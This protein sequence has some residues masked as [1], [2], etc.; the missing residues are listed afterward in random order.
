MLGI[1]LFLL[2]TFLCM[3]VFFVV[4]LVLSLLGWVRP[5]VDSSMSTI[6][7]SWNINLH[8]PRVGRVKMS[9]IKVAIGVIYYLQ[10]ILLPSFSKFLPN[11]LIQLLISTT[12]P[13]LPSKK[14]KK[15]KI[16]I[17]ISLLDLLRVGQDS[18]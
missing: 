6:M 5:N 10:L 1:F 17:I 16:I 14:K 3:L 15:N 8:L 12:P 7:T 11:R 9:R 2:S 18:I 13:P 4:V